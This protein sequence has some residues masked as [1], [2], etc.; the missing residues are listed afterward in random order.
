MRIIKMF[1][2][3]GIAMI[4][5]GITLGQKKGGLGIQAGINRVFVTVDKT[6]DIKVTP[7]IGFHIGFFYNMQIVKDFRV[8][9]AVIY[10]TKGA[11]SEF[12]DGPETFHNKSYVRCIEVPIQ[13]SYRLF[14]LKSFSCTSGV[15]IS[16]NPY[17]DIN[18]Y[19][20]IRTFKDKKYE[21]YPMNIG[22]SKDDN[23][24]RFTSGIKVGLSIHLDHIEPYLGY[25]WGITPLSS[26]LK[27][28]S[29]RAFYF[30]LAFHL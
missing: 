18:I 14:K 17:L 27:D 1:M 7:M 10:I 4:S 23:I 15:Y 12:R 13:C 16:A 22:N 25:D 19:G 8:S 24:K 9:S 3:I 6:V 29:H 20:S 28:N 2:A 26:N 21:D 11:E 5:C 30:G